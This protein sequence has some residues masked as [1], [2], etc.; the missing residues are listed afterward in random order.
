MKR[1]L[2]FDFG[3]S[4]GR[5]ILGEFDGHKIDL[6]EVH[7]FDNDPVM[8]N[9]VFYWDF[10]RLFHEVKQGIVQAKQKGSFSSIG[11]DTWG[12]DFGLLDAN[13]DLL[14]NPVNYRDARTV[15]MI[16]EVCKIIPKEVLY[17]QTGLQFMELNTLFQ[18]F[19]LVQKQP[20][21]LKRAQTALLMPDLFGYF[22]TG[23]KTAE[24]SIAST[25]QMMSHQTKQ[26]NHELLN[27]LSIKS[28]L[29]PKIVPAGT[30]LGAVS[31]S[32]CEELGI[33]DV[34]VIS[35]TGHDTACAV[36]AV[37]TTQKDFVFLSCG[38]WSLLGTE[39]DAPIINEKSS[40]LNITN[41]GGYAGST[42]FLKNIVGLWHVQETR[43]QYQREGTTYSYPE[44]VS[45]AAATPALVSFIDPDSAEFL[46]PG[47][48]PERIRAYCQ[49]THQPIPQS[50][51]EIFQTIYQ[52]LAMKYHFS[53]EQIQDCTGKEYDTVHII[54]GGANATNLCQMT[55]NST[56]RTV[57]AGPIEAT[58]LG[59]I[60]VQLMADGSISS[61]QEARKVIANSFQPAIY[62][63][64]N[65]DQWQ[66]AYQRF[67]QIISS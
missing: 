51:G 28:N 67:T 40:N 16:E 41:E 24:F 46:I 33:C 54:G 11:I 48:I 62:H 61:L 49:K 55:A 21:L 58:A 25:T 27:T 19:S 29:F 22:L 42:H 50:E 9:G 8:M 65:T 37:P 7:R 26:W 1:V 44:I 39:L 64:Q 56:G 32:L 66:Q 43:R 15:G 10:L 47:N 12:V 23:K 36:V 13:G 38:T 52:S 63:P 20:E 4:S 35:V 5:S 60:A 2:A 45:L 18:L 3:A 57:V 14:Q 53:L 6:I 59:N 34:N 31:P 17:Q 30:T